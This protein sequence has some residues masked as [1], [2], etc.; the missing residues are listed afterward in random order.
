MLVL[1]R[2]PKEKI[3]FPNLG[4]SI[5]I[6]RVARSRVQVG[7]EAPQDVKILRGELALAFNSELQSESEPKQG[8]PIGHRVR[9]QLNA[10]HLAVNLTQ[11]QLEA[12]QVEEAL[13][14]LQK[15]LRT[16]DTVDAEL[17]VEDASNAGEKQVE[18]AP[19]PPRALLVEDDVNESELLAGYLRLSGFE[20]DTAEDGLKAMV[21]LAR[22]RPPDVVLMD[23]RMP[24]FD[25]PRT[26]RSIRENPDYRGV[27]V[28][29]VTGSPEA[30]V[31]VEIGPNGVN[32]WFQKPINPT[33]LVA[34]I[35]ED[36]AI[37]K[38]VPQS[39]N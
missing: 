17:T 26:V 30:E 18:F 4:V 11:K 7:V 33:Q 2:G 36:L 39:V 23:M 25:G 15:A 6:L 3:V 27:R 19:S 35:H 1:S 8:R 28:F 10:A 38:C 34:Q 5:E 14:T 24:R 31:Q 9:N 22:H 13:S 20:V 29:A 21:Y 37:G 12:G 32:R 16:F